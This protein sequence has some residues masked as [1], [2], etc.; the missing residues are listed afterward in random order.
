MPCWYQYISDWSKLCMPYCTEP[1]AIRSGIDSDFVRSRMFSCTAAVLI[2]TSDA[3]TRPFPSLRGTSRNDTIACNAVES[4]C[5]TSSCWCGGKTEITRLI[6]WVASVVWSVENT[7][8]PVSAALSA[9]SSVSMS[10]ISPI[11]M[12]SGAWRS[13]WRSAAL[14]DSV[15]FPTSRCEMLDRL[16]RCR[17]SIGSSIVMMFT[18]RLELMWWI[19]AAS[20]VDLPDPVEHRVQVQLANGLH[21]VGNGPKRE[22]HRAALLV[23]VGPES[24]HPRHADREVRLLVLG[25][26]LHLTRG[27]DLLGQ[28]LQLLRLEGSALQRHQ[29]A[30]HADRRRP[31]HLQQQVRRIALD[32][33]R[34]R[35]LEIE[36]RLAALGS[37]RHGGL[38]GK[39]PVRTRRAGSSPPA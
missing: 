18:R 16:S 39:G 17:N 15:S 14:N 5:R 33:V 3:G 38:L 28:R 1:C 34:D 30:V 8:C 25:E 20:A 36:G 22:R 10:R 12:T 19:I 35:R 9:V 4:R 2:S 32:H 31:A 29:L 6:V 23:H 27:H 26:L 13:T 7:R 21:L 37:F 11:R 24:T